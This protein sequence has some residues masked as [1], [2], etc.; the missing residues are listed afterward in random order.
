M[1]FVLSVYIAGHPGRLHVL[2]LLEYIQI[3]LSP[4]SLGYRL[5]TGPGLPY[6]AIKKAAAMICDIS[7]C[8]TH[9]RMFNN[10]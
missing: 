3:F 4:T 9:I 5:R 8:V 6:L 10:W 1:R 2:G 7:A